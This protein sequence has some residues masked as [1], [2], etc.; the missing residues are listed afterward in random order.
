MSWSHN[1]AQQSIDISGTTAQSILRFN[2]PAAADF[3]FEADIEFLTDPGVNRHV[4]LWMMTGNGSEGLRIVHWTDKWRIDQWG[5]AFDNEVQVAPRITDGTKPFDGPAAPTFNAGERR[6]LRFEVASGAFDEHGAPTYRV[7]RFKV[8]GVTIFV[9][10]WS[11]PKAKLIPGVFVYQGT[12]RVHSISGDTPSGLS[13]VPSSASVSYQDEFDRINSPCSNQWSA[14]GGYNTFAIN[15]A[16]HRRNVHFGGAGKIVGT[17]KEKSTPTNVPLVRRVQLYSEVTRLLVG[18]TWSD[19][20]GTYAFT[21]IDMLQKY[22]VISYDHTGIYRAVV[23]DNLSPE[24]M[25]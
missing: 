9:S 15:D 7:M 18:E 2:E 11:T 20:A 14:E 25:T 17:V 10:D 16:P 19:S 8:D 13:A 1:A 23:A 4:G 12:A 22:T 24:M 21:G 6:V 3:W 5:A